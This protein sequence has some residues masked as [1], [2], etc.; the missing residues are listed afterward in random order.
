MMKKLKLLYLFLFVFI[1][2]P[3]L[4]FATNDITI[5]SDLSIELPSDSSSYT[6]GTGTTVQSFTVNNS[7]IDFVVEANSVISLSSADAK[8]F[9]VSSG[10]GVCSITASSCSASASAITVTCPGD[11]TQQTITIT[12]SGTC[13]L[14]VGTSGSGSSSSAAPAPVAEEVVEPE[15]TVVEPDVATTVSG[16]YEINVATAISVGSSSHTVTVL[17]ASDTEAT[18]TIESDPVT[19]NLTKDEAQD[20]D[21]DGDGIDDLRV[22]YLGFEYGNPKLEFT[23]LTASETPQT[24]SCALDNG[25]AYKY[26]SSPGVYYI[27]SNCTKRPFKSAN[28]FFTYFTSWD[29][30]KTTTKASLESIPDDEL[31]FMPY[32]PKY[33]PKYGA[34]VKIVSDPKVY[35]LLGTERYW[36]TSE[37][38]FETLNYAWNWIEDIAVDLL[39]K[40]TIGSEINYTNHHPNYTLVKY[41][42]N[43][44]VYRLEPDPED[45]A[46]Q[47]K[48]WVVNETAFENLG[49]R[50][51]RIVV[52][53]SDE[54]YENGESLED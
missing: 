51:D 41:A 33:D 10:I 18:V 38:V 20:I 7:T 46:K 2:A 29:E 4:V 43:A 23:E 54:V 48:R 35:L 9:G 24:T 1:C 31:N 22:T 15:E 28:M 30:V 49:F 14:P 8:N 5:E 53:S 21:T 25:K 26:S 32:G 40:Y 19:V 52:I 34:L 17:S 39:N 44:K 11:A 47:V 36:I 50:W 6:V 12:P 37:T 16:T 27:T 45:L 3:A 13:S 42:S